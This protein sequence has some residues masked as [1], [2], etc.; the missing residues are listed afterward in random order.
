MERETER[1]RERE[2]GKK[3][4]FD[5]DISRWQMKGLQRDNFSR[6]LLMVTFDSAEIL[7]AYYDDLVIR[8]NTG[9]QNNLKALQS[10]VDH[11]PPLH[12]L[13]CTQQCLQM[14]AQTTPQA[15][16]TPV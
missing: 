12:V 8:R 7:L 6:P 10:R 3:G 15:N 14:A 9:K 1:E 11:V 2:T 5:L 13:F 4:V 16:H